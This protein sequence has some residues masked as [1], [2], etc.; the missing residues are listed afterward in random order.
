MQDVYKWGSHWKFIAQEEAKSPTVSLCGHFRTALIAAHERRKVITFDMLGTYLQGGIPK[1]KFR[2]LK[3]EGK[4]VDKMCDINPEYKEHV[5]TENGWKVLYE[6][7]HKALY[8]MIKSALL[9]YNLFASAL[10]E[11]G[12]VLKPIWSMCCKQVHK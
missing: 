7:I 4:Y 9:W 1:H 10:Q 3:L 6:R 11:Q 12:F 2:I 8:G 5:R